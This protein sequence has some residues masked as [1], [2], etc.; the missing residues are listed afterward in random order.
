[1]IQSIENLN[2]AESL[3]KK[4]GKAIKAIK[5]KAILQDSKKEFVED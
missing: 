1:M 2:L 3:K 5:T 4:K